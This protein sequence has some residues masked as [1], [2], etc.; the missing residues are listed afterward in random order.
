MHRTFEW[1]L[2]VQR[3]LY[4]YVH[5]GRGQVI[6]QT[7]QVVASPSQVLPY[8]ISQSQSHVQRNQQIY[9]L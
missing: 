5:R 2:Q 7:Q 3:I 9:L 8:K 6:L 4:E 1:E